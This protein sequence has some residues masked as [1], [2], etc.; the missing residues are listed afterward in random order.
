MIRKIL[1]LAVARCGMEIRFRFGS[2][3]VGVSIGAY[4]QTTGMK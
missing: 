3:G 1:S 2:N 4:S